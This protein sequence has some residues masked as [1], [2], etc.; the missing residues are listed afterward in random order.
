MN[1]L[2]AIKTIVNRL[3]IV[4]ATSFEGD[5]FTEYNDSMLITYLATLTEGEAALNELVDKFNVRQGIFF[6]F[7]FLLL[8][9]IGRGVKEGRKRR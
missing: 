4:D 7:F 1:I 5:Y 9:S 8:L 2:R 6:F 3:P